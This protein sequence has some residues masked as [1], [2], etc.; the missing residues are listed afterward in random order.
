MEMKKETAI[1]GF[2]II[3][4][5]SFLLGRLTA[6]KKTQTT[7]GKELAQ[8]V[9]GA[10]A[11][12]GAQGVFG[13]TGAGKNL[14]IKRLSPE[15]IRKMR[16][17]RRRRPSPSDDMTV[18]KAAVGNAQCK[19]PKQA[20]VTILEFSEFQCPFCTRVNPTIKRIF[21]EYAGKVRLCFKHNPLFFHKDAKPAAEAAL[22]AGAQGK[23]WQMHDKLFANQRQLKRADLEKYAQE[24]GLDMAKFKKALDTNVYANVIKADQAQ[25]M[26]F[27]ARGT[28]SFF[29]NGRRL[30]G[31]Q[32]FFQFKKI[33]DQELARANSQVKKGTPMDRLYSTLIARGKTRYVPERRPGNQQQRGRPPMDTKTVYKIP[34]GNAPCKGAQNA[35]VT[36][37]VYTEFQCPFS[38]RVTPTLNQLIKDYAG[39]LRV[40]WKNNPLFFHKEAKLAAEAAHSA[41]SQGKFWQMH[42]KL[43]AN[44]RQL[45][46]ADLEKYAQELGLDMAKLKAD[47][48][49]HT[50]A[51]LLTKDQAE[52]RQFGARG[53]PTSFI[54]GRK[55][56]GARPLSQFKTIVD[57]EI[58]KAQALMARGI[59]AANIYNELTKDGKT[60]AAAPPRGR[61]RRPQQEDKTIYKVNVGQAPFKGPANAKITI[62]EYTDIQCPFC[63]RGFNTGNQMIKDYPGKVRVVWKNNPLFFHKDAVL[64]AEA[65]HAAGEQGKFWVMVEKLF[66]NQRKLKRPDLDGFAAEL[67]LDMAKFKAALD[68]RK[69]KALVDADTAEGKKLGVRGTP[70]FFINGR[71][72]V[73]AQP[74]FKFKKLIDEMLKK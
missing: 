74:P 42:D 51:A 32:P 21:S 4:V 19:G 36:I 60:K 58:K 70:T 29:I 55:I 61:G 17:N 35:L 23:F 49:S 5:V 8:V 39:K 6:P 14:D 38:R 33:I 66:N 53:T 44:Q 73:G 13:R 7:T 12:R 37:T 2:V 57:E 11:G 28:P 47:L 10:A 31:A 52:A 30:I 20:L 63:R 50:Y 41:G 56:V 72:L 62:V 15:E 69:Y 71:K 43:F 46:R 48:D 27:G 64:A 16:Q 9:K 68:S 25:A 34:V 26:R 40:C 18:Y 67:G 3:A 45:K 1:V 24:L 59:S 65:A 22:A 54:N